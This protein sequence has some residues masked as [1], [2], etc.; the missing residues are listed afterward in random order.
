VRVGSGV[1]AK[2]GALIAS[3]SAG[4]KAGEYS[5]L[6]LHDE[7]NNIITSDTVN[8]R[9]PVFVKLFIFFAENI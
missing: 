2:M 5:T 9:R 3:G 4:V 6:R 8:V 7:R 1:C